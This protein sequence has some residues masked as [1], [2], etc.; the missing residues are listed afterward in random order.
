MVWTGWTGLWSVF[1]LKKEKVKIYT[2]KTLDVVLY[3]YKTWSVT[4]EGEKAGE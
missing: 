3:R 2:T 1:C 4:L